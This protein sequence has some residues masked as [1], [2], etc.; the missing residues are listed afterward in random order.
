MYTHLNDFLL[1]I[2]GEEVGHFSRV[3]QPVHVLQE[4]LLL[5]LRV[6]DEEHGRLALLAGR[7]EQGLEVLL[8][9]GLPVALGDLGLEDVVVGHR[10]GEAG[11]GLASA[12]AHPHQQSVAARLLDDAADAGQVLQDIPD[13]RVEWSNSSIRVNFIYIYLYIN[14]YTWCSHEY[15]LIGCFHNHDNLLCTTC[16]AV[17]L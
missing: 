2:D 17:L 1:L 16:Q 11:E 13:V 12:A 10:R 7:L 15:T 9:L 6:C 14:M 5:D 3:Q 8:P 4:R